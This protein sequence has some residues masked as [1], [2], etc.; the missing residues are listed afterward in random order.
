[1]ASLS[2][3]ASLARLVRP[4]HGE[5]ELD[6]LLDLVGQAR[7]IVLGAASYGTHEHYDVRASLTRKL[8]N[9]RGFGGVVIEADWPDALR[10]DR[11]VR[12]LGDDDDA[13]SAL[14]LFDHF[15]AWAWRN[16]DVERFIDWLRY[17]N[18]AR[19]DKVGF[20]GLDLYGLN[21]T[22]RAM[23]THGDVSTDDLVT[24]LCD[25]QWRHAARSGRAPSGEA[26]L[27]ALQRAPFEQVDGYYRAILGG[28]TAAWNLRSVHM[29]DTIDMLAKQLGSEDGPAK[30]V[31]WVHDVHAGD[32]RA[33]AVDRVSLGQQLRLR[34]DDAVA[35]V[36]FTTYEGT[37][38]CAPDWDAE[39][40]EVALA[41]ALE[42]S[43]EALFHHTGVPRFMITSS[44]LRRASGEEVQR[45]HRT[46]GAVLRSNPYCDVR[47]AD[48]YDLVVHVDSTRAVVP[49]TP[50]CDAVPDAMRTEFA[51]IPPRE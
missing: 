2:A 27:Y 42:G 49:I 47:L 38:R 34:H 1:M 16:D 14:A 11:Y 32:A 41:P 15:P 50:V 33:A 19:R 12:E 6:Q 30:L 36:G 39:A 44:A 7:I 25:M 21:A 22:L 24:E 5:Y 31:V 13:A 37:V 4:I 10:V 40:S 43:W 46:V 20:Y 17:Y 35:L 3:S 28:G 29:A 9:E 48:H 45:K 26:W 8:I 18:Y 51:G 23:R